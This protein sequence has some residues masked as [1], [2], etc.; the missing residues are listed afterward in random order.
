MLP[1]NSRAPRRASR[2]FAPAAPSMASPSPAPPLSRPLSS[3]TLSL[4]LRRSATCPSSTTASC[5]RTRVRHCLRPEPRACLAPCPC[6]PAQLSSP[7]PL[8][9]PLFPSLPLTLSPTSPSS[10]GHEAHLRDPPQARGA[11]H[12]EPVRAPRAGLAAP[13]A[14]AAR[15]SPATDTSLPSC[16]SASSL[17][18]NR[19]AELE[20]DRVQVE[21]GALLLNGPLGA[22]LPHPSP[23]PASST[24]RSLFGPT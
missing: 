1:S 4:S 6:L 8:F 9:S 14:P 7:L 11:V 16:P 10:Q 22:S 23:A 19:A 3:R 20:R 12:Q 2:A 21:K 15:L 13:L 24:H 17:R 5:G 18:A